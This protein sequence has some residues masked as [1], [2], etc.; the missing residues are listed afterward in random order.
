MKT[1]EHKFV[2][3]EIGKEFLRKKKTIQ[4]ISGQMTTQYN[5]GF[6]IIYAFNK[7]KIYD[8]KNI[9]LLQTIENN[10][11]Y[12]NFCFI[13]S[14]KSFITCTHKNISK[15]FSKNT[16]KFQYLKSINFPTPTFNK[17]IPY[18]K[19]KIIFI[20]DG[21]LQI[22]KTKDNIPSS[23]LL[24][25]KLDISSFDYLI[26]LNLLVTNSYGEKICIFDMKN[27]KLIK[28]IKASEE[29]DER[30]G[31]EIV[32][33]EN[34]LI[35]KYIS[36]EN[37]CDCIMCEMRKDYCEENEKELIESFREEHFNERIFLKL[38]EFKENSNF[39]DENIEEDVSIFVFDK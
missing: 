35:N 36:Y 15:V 12:C 2:D 30:I 17:I 34:I 31:A 19:D 24:I 25:I 37:A 26:K 20:T 13:I 14:E 38:P 11:K 1:K 4:T 39:F 21:S 27:I 18:N 9:N 28:T 6:F 7:L 16:D 5:Y 23:C 3:L 10:I 8:Q 32:G 33:E 22:W 29:Q